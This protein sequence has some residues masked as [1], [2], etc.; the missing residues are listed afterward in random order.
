MLLLIREIMYALIFERI[1]PHGVHVIEEFFITP[2][3]TAASS[4]FVCGCQV[5][6]KHETLACRHSR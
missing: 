5:M 6:K 1:W 4:R 2:N 3:K